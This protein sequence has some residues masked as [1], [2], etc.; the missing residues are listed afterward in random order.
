MSTPSSWL[1]AGIA[2]LAAA[3]A[4]AAL[5]PAAATADARQPKQRV[6]I[7]AADRKAAADAR[8]AKMDAWKQSGGA[9]HAAPPAGRGGAR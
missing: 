9:R 5:A 3:I 4:L 2:A 6:R 1:R 7:S 8:K